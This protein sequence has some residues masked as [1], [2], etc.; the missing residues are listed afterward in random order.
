MATRL[1]KLNIEELSGVEN[2]ANELPGWIVT[3]SADGEVIINTEEVMAKVDRAESDFAILYSALK[4]CE[5]YLTDAPAEVSSAK[6]TL[7]SYIEDLFGSGSP[8]ATDQT[9]PDPN[10]VMQSKDKDKT[11]S[12]FGRLFKR[13][14]EEGEEEVA[15]TEE[16]NVE[17]TEA[18]AEA[19]VTEKTQEEKPAEEEA[20]VVEK[21]ESGVNTD[22]LLKSMRTVMSEELAPVTEDIGTV[23]DAL[24]KALDRIG[25]LEAGR[26]GLD[27]D[28]AAAVRVDKSEDG[29]GKRALR[30]GISAAARGGR[31]TLS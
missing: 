28:D 3:K 21:T 17:K 31:V 25:A 13:D 9:A 23:K 24:G 20:P 26:Q 6:D 30:A 8:E 14:G 5:Q 19:E 27:P 1:T 11:K 12:L 7:V 4:S 22:E 10:A 15:K 16:E 18:E 2:P 29:A